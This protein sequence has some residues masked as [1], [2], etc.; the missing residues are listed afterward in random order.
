L[1][2]PGEDFHTPVQLPPATL[3]GALTITVNQNEI[4]IVSATIAVLPGEVSDLLA[5]TVSG[6]GVVGGLAGET[7]EV[8]IA[9]KDAYGNVIP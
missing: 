1:G 9:G 4:L 7:L 3:A 5:S 8:D 6:T 2:I